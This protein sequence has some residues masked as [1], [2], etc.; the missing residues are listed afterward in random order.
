[1]IINM[2]YVPYIFVVNENDIVVI[3]KEINVNER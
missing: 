1:M 3:D 2:D